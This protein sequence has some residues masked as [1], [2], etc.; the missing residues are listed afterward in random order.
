MLN[1]L[2]LPKYHRFEEKKSLFKVLVNSGRTL[3]G[4][5]RES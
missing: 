4:S 2:R 3:K 5:M 1:L